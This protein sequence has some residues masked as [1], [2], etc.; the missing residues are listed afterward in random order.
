MTS[1]NSDTK[2]YV[3]YLK[4]GHYSALQYRTFESQRSNII[5]VILS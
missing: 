2:D 5:Q 4:V 3:K 1:G